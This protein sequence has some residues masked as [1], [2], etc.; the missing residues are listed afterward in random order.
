MKEIITLYGNL[1]LTEKAV[2]RLEELDYAPETFQADVDSHT[3][4]LSGEP[5]VYCGTY[6][7][8][9][10]GSL[11]GLWVDLSTF[12]DYDELENFCAAIHADE[13]DPELMFQD[14]EGF[15]E[16]FYSE[17]GMRDMFGGI[18]LYS[19]LCDEYGKDAVNAFVSCIG[20]DALDDFKDEFV[21][22]YDSEEAFAVEVLE[23]NGVIEQ[24]RSLSP[25]VDY[26]DY[27]DYTA[28]ANSLF[29][30][31]YEFCDGYVFYNHC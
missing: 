21:G 9:N 5:S 13:D 8:Y 10:R 22:K 24:L 14:Y 4:R 30:D 27:F 7:K 23:C 3:S 25:R 20:A 1:V 26:S 12:D 28:Y 11:R 6:G 19:E 31:G 2:A 16:E 17:S 29:T 15:P 18:M